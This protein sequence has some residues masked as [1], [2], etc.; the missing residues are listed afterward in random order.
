MGARGEKERLFAFTGPPHGAPGFV[1]EATGLFV[2]AGR[3]LEF[4]QHPEVARAAWVT[5]VWRQAGSQAHPAYELWND[6][7][8]NLM[9]HIVGSGDGATRAWM[10]GQGHNLR[11]LYA[12]FLHPLPAFQATLLPYLAQMDGRRAAGGAIVGVQARTGYADYEHRSQP[13]L[14]PPTG[15]LTQADMWDTLDAFHGECPHQP[16]APVANTSVGGRQI[17]RS[18]CYQWADWGNHETAAGIASAGRSCSTSGILPP[19]LAALQL[20]QAARPGVFSSLLRC[21]VYEGAARSQSPDAPFL[22]YVAGD[23]PSFYHL[24]ARHP[25]IGAYAT[26]ARGAAGHGSSSGACTDEQLA[27]G[28]VSCLSGVA[29][30][31]GSWTRTMLDIYLLGAVDVLVHYGYT[32]FFFGAVGIRAV[33]F[34]EHDKAAQPGDVPDHWFISSWMSPDPTNT[35]HLLQEHDYAAWRRNQVALFHASDAISAQLLGRR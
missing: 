14:V 30:P 13:S 26:T 3:I 29:D 25:V 27:A 31:G 21:A 5:L 11:C 19:K 16:G 32:T 15:L 23:L 7:G 35:S 4:L 9:E 24:I 6:A 33:W 12:A 10:T 22:L 28:A 34:T 17:E 20:G 1:E 18:V 8:M 2:P